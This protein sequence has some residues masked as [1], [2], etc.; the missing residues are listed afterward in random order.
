MPPKPP[1]RTRS[2]S[3]SSS[4][5]EGEGEAEE[6][7]VEDTA[8]APNGRADEAAEAAEGEERETAGKAQA[9]VRVVAAMLLQH[10]VAEVAARVGVLAVTAAAEVERVEVVMVGEEL[11]H[12]RPTTGEAQ[13]LARVIAAMLPQHG[14]AEV[15]EVA[16]RVGALALADKQADKQAEAAV[17]VGE[18][19]E[20]RHHR[21]TRTPTPNPTSRDRRIST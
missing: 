17:V 5:E 13:V 2:L 20:L 7:E 11:R 9:L 18:G 19:E 4:C 1:R 3:G 14:V 15:A 8:V 16:A 21:P 12:H 6:E 10:G